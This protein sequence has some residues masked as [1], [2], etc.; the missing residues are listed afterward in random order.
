[1]PITLD[2]SGGIT[3][4]NNS[5]MVGL[6]QSRTMSIVLETGEF[7]LMEPGNSNTDGEIPSYV[8]R[9]TVTFNNV[10]LSGDADESPILQLGSGGGFKTDRYYGSVGGQRIWSNRKAGVFLG[11][12]NGSNKARTGTVI[13][14]NLGGNTWQGVVNVYS[15]DG[16]TFEIQTG[17][18]FVTLDGVLNRIRVDRVNYND[19]NGQSR[20]N[21]RLRTGWFTVLYE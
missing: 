10:T 17:C 16:G 21:T 2:G 7:A 9:L 8:K 20:E 1:M 14:T 3:L 19:N 18:V 4:P 13:F 15:Q 11:C 12:F 6:T 5:T